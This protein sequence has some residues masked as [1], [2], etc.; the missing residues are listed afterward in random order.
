MSPKKPLYRTIADTLRAEIADGTFPPDSKLP[1]ER[2]LGERFQA[3]R[4]TVRMGLNVLLTEGLITSGQ[5]VGYAVQSHEVFVLNASRFENLQFS[6]PTDGD[7][8]DN[9][10]LQAGRMPRQEFRV[11]MVE[12]PKDI[13]GH[14]DVEPASAAVLRHCLRY[15]DDS[16][17]STQA[18]YYPKW[19]VDEHPRL[20]EPRDIEEGTTRY[21]ADR[22]INQIGSTNDVET[23]MPTPNEAR[24][25][26]MG[27]GVPV[28]I[29]TR[30]GY[31]ADKPVRC[32]VTT[33]RGDLNRL[34]FEQGDLRATHGATG[35]L[36]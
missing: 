32:T 19:L 26:Q 4:G 35:G 34:H 23:R 13:A 2:E 31:T 11:Q 17:W 18:T 12:T 21:L 8:Y 28:L 5:G 15:V 3:A 22:G 33:F 30:T 9:E 1:S 16:P 36:H 20:A 6:S 27:P 24:E 25:L 29:W 7:S 14:L 10:V